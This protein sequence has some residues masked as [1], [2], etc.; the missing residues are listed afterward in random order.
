MITS[1]IQPTHRN[2]P[3]PFEAWLFTGQPPEQWPD[4]MQSKYP[5]PESQER[6]LLC[7]EGRYAI[8]DEEGY[9][10]RWMDAEVFVTRFEPLS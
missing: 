2:K 8:R 6:V 5:D 3:H 7:H 1:A 10:Y 4:W 9:F